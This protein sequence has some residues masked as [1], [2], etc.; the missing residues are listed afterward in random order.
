[1]DSNEDLASCVMFELGSGQSTTPPAARF[2]KERQTTVRSDGYGDINFAF[3]S[4]REII[5]Q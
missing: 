3:P 4:V 1:M 5:P 2:G